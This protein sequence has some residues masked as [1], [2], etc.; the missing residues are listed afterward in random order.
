MRISSILSIIVFRLSFVVWITF[1]MS[2]FGGEDICYDILLRSDLFD[3][4]NRSSM[5]SLKMI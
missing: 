4:L 2:V 3:C 1:K 5:L